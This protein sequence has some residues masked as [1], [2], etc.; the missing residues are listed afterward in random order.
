MGKKF[1]SELKPIDLAQVRDKLLSEPTSKGKKRSSSTTNRYLAAFSRILSFAVKELGWL[2]ENPMQ[3]ISK[4]KESRGRDRFLSQNEIEQLLVACETSSN[5]N[6]LFIV[7]IALLTAM[8]YG[9]IVNLKWKDVNFENNF[10]TLHETKNGSRRIIPLTEK[11]IDILKLCPS[12]GG[13]PEDPIFTTGKKASSKN[14]ISIRKSFM[15]ALKISGIENF[16][17]HDLRHT[18]A[19]YLAMKGATQGELMEILGHRSPTMTRR[20]AHYSQSHIT[21]I[22]EKTSSI[23][24]QNKE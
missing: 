20:Y 16:R 2:Q 1:L 19:S 17:F 15:R 24:D 7:S 4:P 5:K 18:S 11:L 6:L 3:K 9:E 12:Y 21:N 14:P 22:L 13:D 8:R 10:L 23:I